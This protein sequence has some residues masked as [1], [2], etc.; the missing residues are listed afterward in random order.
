MN[1][2]YLEANTCSWYKRGKTGVSDS[3]LVYLHFWLDDKWRKFS[4]PCKQIKATS[5]KMQNILDT[6]WKLLFLHSL[7]DESFS[8]DTTRH[9]LVPNLSREETGRMQIL[10]RLSSKMHFRM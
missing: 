4:K 2:S 6:K 9:R 3:R 10:Q 8:E 5:N 1:Q 7:P